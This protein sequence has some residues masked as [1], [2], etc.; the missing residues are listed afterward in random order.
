M[1]KEARGKLRQPP[2][3]SESQGLLHVPHTLAAGNTLA[4]FKRYQFSWTVP[5]LSSLEAPSAELAQAPPTAPLAHTTLLYCHLSRRSPQGA[6]CLRSASEYP[7]RHSADPWPLYTCSGLCR[8]KEAL[9]RVA[10]EALGR[11]QPTSSPNQVTGG[12]R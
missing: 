10:R 7:A 1:W 6:P 3:T 12:K 2:L 8:G 5:C 11:G 4:T 9:G